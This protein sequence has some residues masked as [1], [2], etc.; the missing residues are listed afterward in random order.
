MEVDV[1]LSLELDRP[2]G[3]QN[4]SIWVS[5]TAAC[6]CLPLWAQRWKRRRR[7]SRKDLILWKERERAKRSEAPLS[8]CITQKYQYLF[9]WRTPSCCIDELLDVFSPR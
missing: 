8:Y 6:R 7:R 9:H 4:S 3:T 5:T 2:G 1:G